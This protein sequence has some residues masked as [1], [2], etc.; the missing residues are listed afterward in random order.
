VEGTTTA[1][2]DYLAGSGTLT[3]A[4]GETV[5]TVAITINGDAIAEPNETSTT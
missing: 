2:R 3:F 5:K 1:G 4:I